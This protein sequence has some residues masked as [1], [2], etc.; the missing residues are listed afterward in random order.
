MMTVEW[1]L[2]RTFFVLWPVTVTVWMVGYGHDAGPHPAVTVW[3]LFVG[4]P[5]LTVA[6]MLAWCV[7]LHLTAG[8]E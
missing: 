1:W 2:R 8:G 6:V 5:A 4:L 7:A 3:L